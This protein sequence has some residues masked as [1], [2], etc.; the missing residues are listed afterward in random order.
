MD[1]ILW[2]FRL[3]EFW[4]WLNS[5]LITALFGSSNFFKK[6]W[7]LEAGKASKQAS[8]YFSFYNLDTVFMNSLVG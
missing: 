2:S 5:M 6:N 1:Y 4:I 7:F 3:A 8:F